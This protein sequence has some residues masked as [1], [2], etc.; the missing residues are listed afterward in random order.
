[1]V[2]ASLI[3]SLLS[4]PSSDGGEL[5]A[6]PDSVEWLEVR[7][8]LVGDL[9]P[10]WLRN[11]FKGRLIYALR[12][13]AEGG[14]YSDSTLECHRRLE[15]AAEHYDRV[16]LEGSRDFSPELLATIAPEKRCISWHGSASYL[17]ELKDRF[18]QLASV[19]AAVYKLVTT[20][21][22]MSDEFIPLSLLKTLGR[23]DTIAYSTGP[24]GF[25]SRLAALHLGAPAIFG[26]VPQG[27]SI[28]TEPTINKLIDD[29]GLP[30]LHPVKEI[31]A[32][33]G[34][35]IFH[36]LSPRLHN[37]AYRAMGY[38][39]LFLPLQVESF[40]EFWQDVVCSR[41]LD[42]LG[43]PINGMTVA[44]PHKEAALLTAKMISPMSRQAESANILVRHNGWWKADTTD[45]E[46]IYMAS[47]ERSV[48][49]RHK[50]AAV[51]GCGGAG[52]AIAAA[53]VQSGA[54]VTL[55]N[56]GSE[57]G[58]HASELLGLPYLPLPDFDA[59]GYDIVVNATPVGRDSDEVPFNL[60]TLNDEV[61]VID[62]VYGARPTPLVGNTLARDQI[63]IDGCDV[64]LTQVHHQ[65]RL[66][67]GKEMPANV[68]GEKLGR[69]GSD[70]E[71][72]VTLRQIGA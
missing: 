56:R 34:N 2:K 70:V 1:M 32:I 50:R 49:V 33:I 59:A 43:F 68:A 35:P 9:D 58:M 69:P 25:W 48:Q 12:S 37:A 30:E 21:A 28:P 51:I 10:Q 27:D 19:P 72:T 57:R 44:S 3:A 54:G 52:R 24:L 63:A 15:A 23:T 64:L 20:A 40:D 4:P 47:R 61:V 8:D 18:E 31:F 5:R 39:A 29:Y 36:S 26:L 42:S 7:A 62:L 66:M 65:F 41:V 22:K 71:Q 38:P 55:I 45:P 11:H 13:Q 6:L 17:P 16:E 46:V 67:T 53:L 60:E 14:Q